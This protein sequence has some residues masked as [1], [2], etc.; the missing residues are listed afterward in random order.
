MRGALLRFYLRLR[1]A[2]HKVV[3]AVRR[4][5]GRLRGIYIDYEGN[6]WLLR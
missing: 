6:E 5:F 2:R 3:I 1:V 4:A